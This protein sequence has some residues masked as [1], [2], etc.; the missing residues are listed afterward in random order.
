[1]LYTLAGGEGYQRASATCNGH[2]VRTDCIGQ[3]PADLLFES[4]DYS[5]TVPYHHENIRYS[6]V[7]S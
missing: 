5:M 3:D 4:L 1:M 6:I 7:S 2:F